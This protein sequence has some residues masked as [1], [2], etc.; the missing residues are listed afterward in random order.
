MTRTLLIILA[1]LGLLVVPQ[2]VK[3]RRAAKAPAPEPLPPGDDEG[4]QDLA[5]RI[6]S[7]GVAAGDGRLLVLEAVYDPTIALDARLGPDWVEGKLGDT[8]IRTFTG[9]VTIGPHG[10]EGDNFAPDL[11]RRYETAL[12]PSHTRAAS[13]T[14]ISLA[15]EPGRLESG[16]ARIKLFFE[17]DDD[18]GYDERYAEAYLNIDLAA[19]TAELAEKDSEYRAS[20]V[21]AFGEP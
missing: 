16:P 12:R 3:A 11:D 19:M 21:R 5:F 1:V 15:G 9:R 13:F 20:L 4:W 10:A 17:V 18:E 14:A 6:R 7:A 2:L 8:D